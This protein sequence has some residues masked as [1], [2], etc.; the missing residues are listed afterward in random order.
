MTKQTSKMK[1]RKAP[2]APTESPTVPTLGNDNIDAPVS[3]A[4]P[5]SLAPAIT[6]PAKAE[7]AGKLGAMIALLRR[8]QGATVE[9]MMEATGWQKHSVRGAM[10]GALKKKRGLDI[11]SE[12]AGDQRVYRSAPAA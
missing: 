4:M 3:T 6:A 2:P 5:V 9:Q 10:S 7:P 11:S 12:K 8:S 1:T